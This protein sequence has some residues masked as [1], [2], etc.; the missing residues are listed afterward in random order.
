V[1]AGG[2]KAS[3]TTAIGWPVRHGARGQW[4]CGEIQRRGPGRRGVG[5]FV[6]G[7]HGSG[8]PWRQFGFAGGE[9]DWHGPYLEE[10]HFFGASVE[11]YRRSANATEA[12]GR[13][14]SCCRRG[15]FPLDP[16]LRY[17]RTCRAFRGFHSD[18]GFL[19]IPRTQQRGARRGWRKKESGETALGATAAR[20][21][22]IAAS[23][24]GEYYFAWRF[25]TNSK[26]P[27]LP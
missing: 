11:V 9:T 15:Q 19:V 8:R 10:S 27:A 20:A 22:T 6:I 25:A 3:R 13:P 4:L 2:G 16:K 26:T 23:T 5:C 1:L 17:P 24:W 21:G 7:R 18:E 12:A 14:L